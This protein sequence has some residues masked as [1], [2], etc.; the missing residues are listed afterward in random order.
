[1]ENTTIV[2]DGYSGGYSGGTD[3]FVENETIVDDQG[4]YNDGY[5]VHCS[6]S[7]HGT[8][9]NVKGY[10]S[11][12][13][14]LIDCN[15]GTSTQCMPVGKCADF[16]YHADTMTPPWSTRPLFRTIVMEVTV[17][18]VE[19]TTP[20]RLP[21]PLTRMTAIDLWLEMT[22]FPKQSIGS[23]VQSTWSEQR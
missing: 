19:M 12:A 11:V 16:G 23:I 22:A 9:D 7:L 10:I 5:V 3:T 1:M 18:M 4:G 2:D 8:R 17:A 15:L 6:V 14:G 20:R 13:L 21:P